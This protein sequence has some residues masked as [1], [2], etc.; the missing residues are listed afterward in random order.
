MKKPKVIVLRAAGTNCDE[1]TRFS[2]ELC[3][4]DSELVHVNQLL[5][6]EKSLRDYHILVVPGG[7][8]Y[9]DDLGAGRVL[10]NILR[11]KLREQME[12]FI[13]GG[14]LV[15]GIC[16]GFQVLVKSR[17]LPGLD[18]ETQE[19]TLSFN[20]SGRFEDRWVYLKRD[21][22]D[23]CVFTQGMED[24]IYLPVAH[25]EGKFVPKDEETFRKLEKNNQ[26]VLRYVDASGNPAGYPYNPNGSLGNVAGVCDPTGKI[27][28]LMPHPE[29][30]ILPTQHPRWTRWNPKEEPHGLPFFRNGI[31]W[32]SKNL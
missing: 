19:A 15:L 17:Y 18:G 3:G 25:S 28:G 10:A 16:N 30:H 14:K 8:T 2:F 9:G 21:G 6:G 32:V 27:F 12:E 22:D 1:E 4:G 29:R 24:V 13:S 5:R 11:F 26:A 31:E 23:S 20:D 7:F